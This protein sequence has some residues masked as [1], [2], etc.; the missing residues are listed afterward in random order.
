VTNRRSH[1]ILVG[2]LVLALAGVA[3]LAIPGS[4]VHK[5]ATLG[6]DLQG[7]LEVVLRAQPPKHRP[8]TTDG[9]STATSIMNDRVNSL[10]LSE[11]EI[12]QQGKNQIVIELA[13][14]HDPAKAAAIIG[15]TAQL[16]FFDLENDVTGASTDGN[17]GV[18]A[19]PSLYKLLQGEQSSL[20]S[21][22]P[23]GY[24]LF[25]GKKQVKGGPEDTREKLLDT[26]KLQGKLP[27]GWTVLGVPEHKT[28]VSC[29]ASPTNGCPGAQTTTGKY[30]YLFKYDPFNAQ[31]P[32]PEATGGDLKLSAISAQV[33]TQPSEGTAFVQ[34]G[35]KNEGNKKFHEI[36][37]SEASRGQALADQAGKGSAS[38]L[39]TVSQFAQHF[40]IV[41]D[42]ELKST[43]Y[44][45][46]K[47]NPGGIDPS[48][49]GAEISNINSIGEAKDLAIVL[50]SGALPYKFVQIERT[51]VS[52]TLGKDSLKQAKTAALIGLLVVAIFLLILYRF[53]GVVAVLG[54]GIYAAFLYGV[55]LGV[56]PGV[57]P[58]LTLPGFAGLILTIGVAA[59]ANVVIFERIKEEVRAG[60]SVRA[61]IGT[62]YA[63]GFH[64]IID[65]N[66]VTI[67]TAFILV[68]FATA[69]VKGFAVMLVIGTLISLVTAVAATRA[70]LGLLAG[71]KWFDNPSFMG[72]Q[73]QQTAKWLQIDFMRRRY[74]WFAISG[75]IVAIGV[76]SLASKGLNLGIDFKGGTQVTF[77]T[78][79][80]VSLSTVRSEAT[81]FGSDPVVQGRGKLYGGDAYKNFQLRLRSLS[82]DKTSQLS[83]DISARFGH[84][85]QL[86]SQ[87]QTVSS[88]FGRQ[89]RDAAIKAIIISILLIV[90]YIAIRFDFKFAVP[91]IIALLHDIVITVGIYSLTGREVTNATVAAVLTVLGYSIYDTIIIFDRIRENVPLMRRAPFATIANVSL[92]ETIRRSLATTLI[93]LLPIISL[94]IFGGATLKDFAFALIVGITAGAY[95]S[96][97]IAAPLLTT[98]KEREPEYAR[99][100]GEEPEGG[101]EDGGFA[102]RLR[103]RLPGGA[104]VA[105]DG[106][107]LAL[108]EATHAAAAEPAPSLGDVLPQPA[109]SAQA[110]RER[111]RQRRS[112]KP[113]GRA[114]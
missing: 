1:L 97:F 110:K 44:I 20:K 24:Y 12:R 109:G 5:K 11:P 102:A 22:T 60:K 3:L 47:Q 16:Q 85:Q 13:G 84:G 18:I 79:Q 103:P 66:V 68:L 90:A 98:W 104:P 41:L 108:E 106:G 105:V 30:W 45:D 83:K 39:A 43:P 70:M 10:G 69:S 82:S 17:G 113:H 15:K 46:Y 57:K 72:A 64:T 19:T 14:V 2:L 89:I 52:A 99:R 58:T 65:A 32:V 34:L 77:K 50:K 81:K 28:I 59:D 23:T 31:S 21:G 100:K 92:W 93:T 80:P 75:A 73:G 101:T 26:E 54:L 49:G 107:T 8:V 86:S 35:F 94:L 71:F 95:S 112:T 33:G 36:T 88:S 67:I 37:G 91:V 27:K 51:D 55:I 9:M 40:A 6:L 87:I 76:G 7:G 114:R 4:P 38:D 48:G 111:R 42:G 63:K 62:G 29:T 78:P 53:L 56:L 25:D 61:A 96:I 74:L